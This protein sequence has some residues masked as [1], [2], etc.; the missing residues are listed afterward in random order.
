MDHFATEER[1]TSIDPLRE[2]QIEKKALYNQYL[3][4]LSYWVK[5]YKMVGN[6]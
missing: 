4:I 5:L 2:G 6:L 1:Q 3:F